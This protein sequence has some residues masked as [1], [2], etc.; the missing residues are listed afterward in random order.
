[1]LVACWFRFEFAFVVVCVLLWLLRFVV[2]LFCVCWFRFVLFVLFY[3]AC[4]LLCVIVCVR[5]WVLVWFV[6]SL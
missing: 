6:L 3:C 1:M 5:D 2:V 4:C